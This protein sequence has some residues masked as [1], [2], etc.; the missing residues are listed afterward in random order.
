[1]PSSGAHDERLS[2]CFQK[3]ANNF[4]NSTNERRS[5]A[6]RHAINNKAAQPCPTQS[7]F[8]GPLPDVTTQYI[9]EGTKGSKKRH[10]KHL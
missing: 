1:M 4:Q 9:E 10:K 2:R 5:A 3:S 7:S 6:A 8:R